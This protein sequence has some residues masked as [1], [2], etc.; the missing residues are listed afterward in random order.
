MLS[1]YIVASW[2]ALQVVDILVDNFG[3]PEW[4]PAFALGLLIIGLPIVLA[5]AF[6]QEGGPAR[7]SDEP[8]LA[9]LEKIFS[10]REE[11]PGT[12]QGRA[13][14]LFTWRNAITG[15]ILAFALWGVVAAGWILFGETA[16]RGGGDPDPSR[17]SLAV[18]PFDN[19][20]PDEENAYFAAGIHEEILTQ[21]SKIAGI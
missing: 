8:G 6:V 3:L 2:V 14:S 5:T 11:E 4:F 21:L 20:S 18:L 10:E 19:L 12:E 16:P 9:D 7:V 13:Y 17:P 1:V 15:G